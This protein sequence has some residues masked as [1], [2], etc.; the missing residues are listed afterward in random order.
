MGKKEYMSIS[1]F[2][3]I[4][5]VSRKTLIYYDTIGL[6][7]PDHIKENGYRVYSHKQIL[8]ITVITTLSQMGVKLEEIKSYLINYNPEE[9][10]KFFQLKIETI[11]ENIQKLSAIKAMMQSRIEDIENLDQQED[12]IF[13]THQKQQYF[14]LVDGI[15]C[16]TKEIPS[17]IWVDFFNSLK[18]QGLSAGYHTTYVIHENSL[19]LGQFQQVSQIGI[20]I[21]DS[22]KANYILDEGKYLIS[23][24]HTYYGDTKKIYEEMINY[25]KKHKLQ[26]VGSAYEEYVVDEL[27][28]KSSLDYRLKICIKIL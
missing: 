16:Y 22:Q 20:R 25:A 1:Q 7:K 4:A 24:S 27:F 14:Y 5:N 12:G 21:K 15:D 17:Q 3:K 6:F 2:S 18:E 13:I 9:A 23:Y 19:K 8:T 26:L 10:K 28:A 11:E